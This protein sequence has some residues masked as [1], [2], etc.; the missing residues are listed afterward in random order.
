[1]FWCIVL[2]LNVVSV[3]T[4]EQFSLMRASFFLTHHID[5][6]GAPFTRLQFNN[7][8][9]NPRTTAHE[10]GIQTCHI[11]SSGLRHSLMCQ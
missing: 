5:S 11:D 9:S 8:I 4:K 7:N 1:M 3:V 2:Q 10:A 6:G